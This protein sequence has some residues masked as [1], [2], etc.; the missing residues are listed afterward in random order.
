M[1]APIAYCHCCA[2]YMRDVCA[3]C[4]DEGR[5]RYLEPEPPPVWKRPF[6]PLPSASWSTSLPLSVWRCSNLA[7][8]YAQVP[9]CAEMPRR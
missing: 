5:Y 3:L 6:A 7:G 4:A 2:N 9:E 1:R 8:H